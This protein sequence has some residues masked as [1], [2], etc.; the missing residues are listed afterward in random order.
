MYWKKLLHKNVF[1]NTIWNKKF[2]KFKSITF[3]H[4]DILYKN[5]ISKQP[6]NIKLRLSY[7]LFLLKR[8]N[9][10]LKAKNELLI[11]NKFEKNFG[12]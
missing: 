9:K 4:A 11:L 12:M 5:A 6:F 10:K 1:A 2:W 3:E 7:I 8:M